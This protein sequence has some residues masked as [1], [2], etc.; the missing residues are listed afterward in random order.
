MAYAALV[1][2]TPLLFDDA[3]YYVLGRALRVGEI[4]ASK[5]PPGY[6]WLLSI[7][8]S[9]EER[10][11]WAAHGLSLVATLAWLGAF[12]IALGRGVRAAALAVLAALA[13]M[14]AVYSKQL[15][16]PLWPA[17]LAYLAEGLWARLR[18]PFWAGG[19]VAAAVSLALLSVAPQRLLPRL[20]PYYRADYYA[21]YLAAFSWLSESVGVGGPLC[22]TPRAVGA[23][24]LY[25]DP[26]AREIPPDPRRVPRDCGVTLLDRRCCTAGIEKRWAPIWGELE[27]AFEAGPLTVY[28]L[29]R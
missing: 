1:P 6:P 16:F 12:W 17:F 14:T 25:A 7:T 3:A 18:R 26:R 19:A 27:P 11:G 22:V 24:R 2:R 20:L 15:L 28:R 13:P 8:Q 10:A 9:L 4:Y 29:R 23:A 5:S 21:S